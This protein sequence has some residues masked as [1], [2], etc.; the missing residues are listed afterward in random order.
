MLGAQL[1]APLGPRVLGVPK[2]GGEKEKKRVSKKEDLY[3]KKATTKKEKPVTR[4]AQV[5]PSHQGEKG[6]EQVA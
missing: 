4:I 1:G 2:G 3:T 5:K 6:T